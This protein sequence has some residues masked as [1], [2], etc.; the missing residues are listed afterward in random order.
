[1][2]PCCLVFIMVCALLVPSAIKPLFRAKPHRGAER[3]HVLVQ[4]MDAH[5]LTQSFGYISHP[6]AARP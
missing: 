6:P 1:M 4:P 5:S 3:S 2:K